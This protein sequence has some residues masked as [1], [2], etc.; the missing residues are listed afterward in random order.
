MVNISRPLES[1]QDRRSAVRLFQR[2]RLGELGE[3]LGHLERH[4]AARCGSDAPCRHDRTR[5][6][7]IPHEPGWEPLYPMHRYGVFASRWP[8]GE[9]TVWTIV[10]RNEYDVTGRQMDVPQQAGIR[11]FDLYH[12]IELSPSAKATGRCARFPIEAHGYGAILATNG[13]PDA[14]QQQLMAKMKR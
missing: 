6:C 4:H 12:G 3:Y 9:K 5:R 10:N 2:R 13:E 14:E 7:A 1:R 8:L 11:Y